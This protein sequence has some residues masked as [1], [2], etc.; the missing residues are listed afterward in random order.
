MDGE[1]RRVGE[2]EEKMKCAMRDAKR[3]GAIA[4]V[5][6]FGPRDPCYPFRR[7]PYFACRAVS[8]RTPSDGT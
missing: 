1:Q 4:V 2:K 3:E 7:L 8:G 5:V 6:M